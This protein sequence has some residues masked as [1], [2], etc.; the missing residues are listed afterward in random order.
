M[1]DCDDKKSRDVHDF[2]SKVLI[3]LSHAMEYKRSH[4]VDNS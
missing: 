1:K 2:S 4:A 3:Y